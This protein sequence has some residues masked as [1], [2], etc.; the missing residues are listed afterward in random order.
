MHDVDT[1]PLLLV[2][3][4]RSTA[5]LAGDCG[6][7]SFFYQRHGHF[8]ILYDRVPDRAC[9]ASEHI[10]DVVMAAG[11]GGAGRCLPNTGLEVISV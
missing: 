4:G 2:V 10:S 1:S 9:E 7:P 8:C 11:D 5:V 6:A 3:I